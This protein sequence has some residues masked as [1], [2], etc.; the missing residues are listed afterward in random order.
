MLRKVLIGTAAFLMLSVLNI[1]NTM[2][3]EANSNIKIDDFSTITLIPDNEESDSINTIKL[4]LD[5]ETDI[6]ADVYFEFNPEN[7]AK[8][9]EYRYNA[10]LNCLNI[11]MADTNSLFKGTD[12]LNI[13]SVFAKDEDGN[14]VDVKVSARKDSLNYVYNTE[15]V[16]DE[17][18]EINTNPVTTTTTTSSTTTTT[19]ASST[20][21]KASETTTSSATT[22]KA[23]ETT[24]SSTTTT[25]ASE[26]TTS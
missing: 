7:S 12:S 21:T 24:T 17:D 15:L 11:Y 14:A 6:D 3:A 5:V 13:G 26:T 16:Y 10:D 9:S 2:D 1:A 23:S 8:I 18:I 25:K 19:T 4:S 22:T 20:T